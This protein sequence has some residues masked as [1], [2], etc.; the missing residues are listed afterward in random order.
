VYIRRESLN[1]WQKQQ[2]SQASAFPDLSDLPS[3]RVQDVQDTTC[4]QTR[5]LLFVSA[6]GLLTTLNAFPPIATK[7]VSQAPLAVSP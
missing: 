5:S 3:S 1:A 2:A 7:A 4:S 6:A